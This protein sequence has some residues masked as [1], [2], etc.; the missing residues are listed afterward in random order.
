[1]NSIWNP[2]FASS[3]FKA[4]ASSVKTCGVGFGFGWLE[5]FFSS[6]GDAFGTP[7]GD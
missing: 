1:M 7:T 4:L 3:I 5:L 2:M 6:S